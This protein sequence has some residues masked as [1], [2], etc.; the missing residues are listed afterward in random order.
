LAR[1]DELELLKECP[2]AVAKAMEYM[3]MKERERGLSTVETKGM[4]LKARYYSKTEDDQP[5][6]GN[7]ARGSIMRARR[8]TGKKDET[9]EEKLLYR[10]LAVFNKYNNKWFMLK[11]ED[12]P[13]KWEKTKA[14]ADTKLLVPMLRRTVENGRLWYTTVKE[15]KKY[16]IDDIYR[17]ISTDKVLDIVGEI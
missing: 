17:I 11:Q 1:K 7:L 10:V 12:L 14:T 8:D 6:E 13:L 2:Y 9:K 5:A 4:S 16:T 15:D 3:V